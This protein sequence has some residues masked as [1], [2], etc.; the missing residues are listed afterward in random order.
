MRE[1]RLSGSEGG[2]VAHPTLPTP[3]S[4]YGPAGLGRELG[5]YS[6]AFEAARLMKPPAL[7]GVSDFFRAFRRQRC[8]P[9]IE[10]GTIDFAGGGI[11]CTAASSDRRRLSGWERQYV[12]GSVQ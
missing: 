4:P 1:I 7:R 5:H 10:F 2:G 9:V 8:Y 3:I 12:T 11:R 6:T